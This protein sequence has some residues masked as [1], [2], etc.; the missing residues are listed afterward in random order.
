MN[1]QETPK[2]NHK[3]ICVHLRPSAVN[4]LLGFLG[5]LGDSFAPQFR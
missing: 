4:S 3:S 2:E 1:R 5:V